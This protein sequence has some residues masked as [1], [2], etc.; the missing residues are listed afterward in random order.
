M[1]IINALLK[2]ISKTAGA[3][4]GKG[5][6]VTPQLEKHRLAICKKC[7]FLFRPTSTCKKC[8]CFVEEKC[9]YALE[10]CPMEKW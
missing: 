9:K 4:L 10:K 7:Y 5:E 6:R 1:T 3:I 2:P 8:K